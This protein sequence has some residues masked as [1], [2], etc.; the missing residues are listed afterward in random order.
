MA[1]EEILAIQVY[2]QTIINLE[3]LIVF[4]HEFKRLIDMA[5]CASGGKQGIA[6]AEEYISLDVFYGC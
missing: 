5:T 6:I 1:H 2:I 3:N 4:I